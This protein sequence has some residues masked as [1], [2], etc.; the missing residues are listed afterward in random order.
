MY[1]EFY[2]LRERPFELT[3]NHRFLL[4][5]PKHREALSTLEY[6]LF[7]AKSLTVLIGEAGTGKTTL[8]QAALKSERCK[9]VRCVYIN[10]PS[11]TRPEFIELLG[12]A[13]RLPVH[14]HGSK[15]ALLEELETALRERRGRGEVTA[16]VV[17]EAQ[18]LTTELLEEVRLLGNIETSNEKLLPLVLSGQPELDSRLEHPSF[19]QLKQRVALRCV[20]S[21][22]ELPETAA[23]IAHRI[24]TAGG[25]P[26]HLFTRE[27]VSLIHEC[28]GGIPRMISVICDNALVSGLAL[29]RRPIDRSIVLEV[30]NEFRLN[31]QEHFRS[32]PEGDHERYQG[33][34]TRDGESESANEAVSQAAPQ[35]KVPRFRRFASFGLGRS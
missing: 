25:V 33:H 9:S 3:A 28:S 35:D 14:V 4:M 16:L 26:S 17:D 34:I 2:G 1:Q 8:L 23:Y 12:R 6:G 13:F 19:R 10:N 30:C 31:R 27:S 7:S 24:R 11:L 29:D 15:T 18:S 21:P 20:L 32:I 22:L 5:T